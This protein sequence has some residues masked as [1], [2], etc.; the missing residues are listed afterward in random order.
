MMHFNNYAFFKNEKNHV[1]LKTKFHNFIDNFKIVVINVDRVCDRQRE[2]Y[3][4]DLD[5]IKQRLNHNFKKFLY[6][7]FIVYITF[8]A[9]KKI[10]KHYQRLLKTQKKKIYLLSC[11]NIFKR[12]INLFC[13]H[14]I[15]KRLI[16]ATNEK[17]LK[18]K[19]IYYY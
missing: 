17:I 2:K 9:L 12:T 3:I 8:F 7:D 4:S 10:N 13:L 6:R 19:N 18:L 1:K 11:I 5:Y 16:D 14:V 15:E